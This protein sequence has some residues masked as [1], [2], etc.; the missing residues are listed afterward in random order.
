MRRDRSGLPPQTPA[1]ESIAEALRQLTAE[2]REL[3]RAL[4]GVATA[5]RSVEPADTP[6]CYT[7]REVAEFTQCPLNDVRALVDAGILRS[8]KLGARVRVRHSDLVSLL[9]QD[10]VATPVRRRLKVVTP[11]NVTSNADWA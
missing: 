10:E 4:H 8:R 6:R 2:M 1:E 11:A 9:D 3:K 7:L 5:V